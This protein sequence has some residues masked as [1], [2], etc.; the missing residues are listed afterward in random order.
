MNAL[1]MKNNQTTN[2]SEVSTRH[3]L[4]E[5]KINIISVICEIRS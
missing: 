5:K 3:K 1:S 4:R 2:Y